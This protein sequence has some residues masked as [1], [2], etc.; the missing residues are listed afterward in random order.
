MV[1]GSKYQLA[2]S[3]STEW[4]ELS[5]VQNNHKELTNKDKISFR[6]FVML[7]NIK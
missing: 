7:E 1:E 3:K 5:L 2:L 6:S 4:Q